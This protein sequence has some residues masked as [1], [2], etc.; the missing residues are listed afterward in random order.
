MDFFI[1][2]IMKVFNYFEFLFES[3]G[4]KMRIF[5]S[6]QFRSLLKKISSQDNETARVISEQLLS[7]ESKKDIL[8]TYTLIDITDKNDKI[9]YVQT[10]RILRDTGLKDISSFQ[11]G[12]HYKFWREG[13]T[14]EFAVGRWVRRVFSDVLKAPLTDPQIELFVNAYKSVYD[15]KE[16]VDLTVVQGED[17]R[18]NYLESNYLEIKGQLGNSCM[19]YERCQSYLDIY[20]ENPEVCKLL[21]LKENGKVK[22]RTLLWNLSDG[23]KYMDRIYTISDSD[24][25]I[26]KEWGS[27]NG[28]DINYD[29]STVN[30]DLSVKL[31]TSSFDKYPYM[32]TF[33]FYDDQNGILYENEPTLKDDD[34]ILKLKS[35]GGSY[36]VINGDHEG[37]VR[38]IDGDWIDEDDA[39]WCDDVDGYVWYENTIWMDYIGIYVSDRADTIYSEYHEDS[40][41]PSDVVYNEETQD[42]YNPDWTEKYHI[43]LDE[44][45]YIPKEYGRYYFEYNGE[46]WSRKNFIID[47]Y[48]KKLHWRKEKIDGKNYEDFLDEK[49]MSELGLPN[50]LSEEELEKFRIEMVDEMIQNSQLVKG[51]IKRIRDIYKRRNDKLDQPWYYY[52][53]PI[54]YNIIWKD[55]RGYKDRLN[56]TDIDFI[57]SIV[58]KLDY[59]A[60]RKSVIKRWLENR[61]S[62]FYWRANIFAVCNVIYPTLFGDSVYKK[63]LY[64]TN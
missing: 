25:N 59:P 48:T 57:F 13:R 31:K 63:Y 26:F 34:N 19:R 5:Y 7:S 41:W 38:D 60:D 54:I 4:G 29:M 14:P 10:N 12:S 15:S 36:E 56:N 24:K 6:D 20:V 51:E 55:G 45:S 11:P 64:L 43:T 50:R 62:E 28:F 23:R 18:N 27:K 17:I 53:A 49:I 39:R 40:F 35:T 22:G 46:N 21:V 9:S 44:V 16:T 52:L 58:D 3:S 61:F 32:D 8:D 33:E 30:E 37:Q 42:Y 1:Y 47:P 2:S